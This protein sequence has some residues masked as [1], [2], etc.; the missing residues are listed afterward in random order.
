MCEKIENVSTT[1][2]HSTGVRLV[3]HGRWMRPTACST[4]PIGVAKTQADNVGMSR[5]A[6]TVKKTNGVERGVFSKISRVCVMHTFFGHTVRRQENAALCGL[7]TLAR[8][9]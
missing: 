3:A 9:R 2:M 5:P 6:R 4:L 7:G 8:W 1:S